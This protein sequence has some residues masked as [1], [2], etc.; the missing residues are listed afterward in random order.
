[1]KNNQREY[2]ISQMCFTYRHDFGLD[3][4]PDDTGFSSGVAP[5]ERKALWEQMAQIFDNAVIPNMEFRD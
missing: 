5:E 1:M 4:D 2:V 3:K